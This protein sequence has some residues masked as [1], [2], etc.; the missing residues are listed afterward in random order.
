MAYYLAIDIGASSGRHILGW[1]EDGKIA[2]EEIHRFPNGPIKKNGEL[3]W[4]LDA[5]FD[6]IL[7]GM[8]RCA[9]LGKLPE[10]VGIDTWGVDFV[11]LDESGKSLGNTVA[12]R[13]NRTR[14][15]DEETYR[16]VPE[17]ELYRRTGIAKQIY[18]TVFQLMAVKKK[19]PELLEQAKQLLL[20]PNYLHYRLCGAVKN[21]YTHATTSGLVNAVSKDWDD[22]IL[23]ACGFP[24]EI[25]AEI[26]PPGT[27]LGNLTPEI[28]QLVG[29]DCKVVAP[30]THDTASAVMALPTT[31]ENTLYISSGTWSLMGVERLSPDC[32]EQSRAR[33]FTNEGGYDYRYRYLKNI[34][35]LWMIQSVKKELGNKYTFDELCV[36]AEKSGITSLVDCN[37]ERFLAP[38]SMIGEIRKAC[39][40]NGQ[41]VPET[42]GEL[43]AV[44]YNSLAH[45]YRE[46]ALEL[47]G[48][49]G[50]KYGDIHIVGGGS[51]DEYLN[52]LTAKTTGKNVLA[53][54][55]EATA[56]GN[57]M[58]QMI[59]AG[60][61]KGL[62][63]GRN[64]VLSG[65][66]LQYEN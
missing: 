24:R 2:Y 23:E 62:A 28:Q 11:L 1:I 61:L 56:I 31:E 27:A 30:C 58:A 57:L 43:A 8:K 25:F 39:K 45:C 59:A 63:E 49:T 33:N 37:S 29:F 34:M 51:K 36:L 50:Q 46:A 54:P 21:E 35:G 53:G 17:A 40:E 42:P 64:A 26:V 32:S 14:G 18:N 44:V 7:R 12:Y 38:E 55:V 19:K 3:C 9:E 10:S 60:E 66:E 5:L 41:A 20:V 16:H 15:M 4:D 22:E 65:K 48:L 6:E 52:R 13:D 47:E